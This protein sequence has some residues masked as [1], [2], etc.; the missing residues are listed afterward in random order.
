MGQ[1]SKVIGIVASASLVGVLNLSLVDEPKNPKYNCVNNS[2]YT[3]AF[4]S[5]ENGKKAFP[6][7]KTLWEERSITMN[8]DIADNLHI[9][10]RFL[11]LKD[12]WDGEGA[13]CFDKRLIDFI[14]GYVAKLSLQPEI[15]PLQDG[16]IQLEYGN[17]RDKYLEFEIFLDETMNVYKIDRDKGKKAVANIACTFENL[18]REVDWFE[19]RV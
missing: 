15:F 6:Q 13:K 3:F 8:K 11:E 5:E 7:S 17:V 1:T 4:S 10:Q 14:S 16:S 9:L 19:N 2:Y 18:K 12:N